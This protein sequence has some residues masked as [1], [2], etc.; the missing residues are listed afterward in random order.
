MDQQLTIEYWISPLPPSPSN[1]LF[2]DSGV[3]GVKGFW[4]RDK[5]S[6][7]DY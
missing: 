3:V 7:I 4:G 2:G 1:M 6:T 5:G